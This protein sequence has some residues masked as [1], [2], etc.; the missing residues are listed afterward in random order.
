MT[1]QLRHS[2]KAAF[3]A[4]ALSALCMQ[5]VMAAEGNSD[6]A[7][8]GVLWWQH[9]ASIPAAQNPLFD[10][11]GEFCTVGQRD[12]VWFL[13]GLT[14]P[15]N[16]LG[17]PIVRNCRIPTGKQIFVPFINWVCVP[18]PGETIAQNVGFCKDANDLTDMKSLSI[19]GES[20]NDLIERLVQKKAFDLTIPDGNAFGWPAGVF[21]AVHDGYFARL[22]KLALGHHT[23]HIQGGVS[24]FDFY[25]DVIYEIDIVEPS[26]MPAP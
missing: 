5:T 11:T 3:V 4:A 12:D 16:A 13:H 18:Y 2:R 9:A 26:E 19:D 17:D 6:P 25:I 22:P 15:G 1:I 23:I 10:L 20:R 21:T 14:Y 7:K 8:L 24:A